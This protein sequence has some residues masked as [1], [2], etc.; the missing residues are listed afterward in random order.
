MEELEGRAAQNRGR[1]LA[2]PNSDLA[3]SPQRLCVA[4]W[5]RRSSARGRGEN[6]SRYF[7]GLA[8][9][10]P[11]GIFGRGDADHRYGKVGRENDRAIRVRS[12]GLLARGYASGR[13]LRL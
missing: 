11:L 9:A 5:E 4:V 3:Q 1:L 10:E 12:S 7:E 13:S 8:L 2:Q 6:V